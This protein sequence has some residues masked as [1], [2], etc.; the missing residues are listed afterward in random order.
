MFNAWVRKRSFILTNYVNVYYLGSSM[1]AKHTMQALGTS[2]RWDTLYTYQSSFPIARWGWGTQDMYARVQGHTAPES[3]CEHTRKMPT[4][5]MLHMLCN[6]YGT[7]K[8]CPTCYSLCCLFIYI[9]TGAVYGY[10]V[11]ILTFVWRLL[12]YIVKFN[13]FDRGIYWYKNTCYR[14]SLQN[15]HL[16]MYRNVS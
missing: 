9:M 8:I 1:S 3:G 11:L 6:T 12:R 4:A 2:P 5:H 14:F 16:E 7:L 15:Q 13:S 10:G